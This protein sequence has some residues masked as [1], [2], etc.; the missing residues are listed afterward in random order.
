MNNKIYQEYAEGTPLSTLA[1]RYNMTV[2][3]LRKMLKEYR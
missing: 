2:A 1:V 3:A